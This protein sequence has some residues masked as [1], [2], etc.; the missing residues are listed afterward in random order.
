MPLLQCRIPAVSVCYIWQTQRRRQRFPASKRPIPTVRQPDWEVPLP[1]LPLPLHTEATRSYT[2]S[3]QLSGLQPKLEMGRFS[4]IVCGILSPFSF[5]KPN[6]PCILAIT[7][8]AGGALFQNR[9][10]IC[11]LS[12]LL[13]WCRPSP[14]PYSAFPRCQSHCGGNESSHGR[15]RFP[16]QRYPL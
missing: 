14:L 4:Q 13:F 6:T 15:C 11:L 12:F 16:A 9:G 3:Q 8:Y 1:E 10:I 2:V 5:P 7:Q